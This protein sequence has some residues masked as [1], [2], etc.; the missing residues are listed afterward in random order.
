MKLYGLIG[1]PLTHSFSKQYF[2]DKFSKENIANCIYQNFEIEDIQQLSQLLKTHPNFCGLNITIPYKEKILDYLDEKTN[3][4]ENINACNCI[5]IVEGRKLIGFNTDV[6]GF[7][8][9]LQKQL[10]PNHNKAIVLGTGG[11]SK[12]VQYT[13]GEL[14]IKYLVVS[15][16]KKLDEISYEDLDETTMNE[17][18]LIINSTPLGMYPNIDV[19]PSVPY[20]YIT[21]KNFLYD[22]VYNPAK[23]KFL[24]EGEKR[25]A[26]I[27]NGHE[28]LV[29]QAEE[30]WRI[31]NV[32]VAID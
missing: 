7:K 19:A 5:K 31:W 12:A 29:G 21:S 24:L 3:V 20:E 23:T 18:P 10:Q 9:S 4:V 27:C 2:T 30:S 32:D 16:N 11:A 13:L 22:L 25:G 15:R 17:Y 28:M 1:Y 14:G 6:F 8:N 26:Q